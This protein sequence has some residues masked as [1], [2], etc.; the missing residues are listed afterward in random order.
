MNIFCLYIL[1]CYLFK[2][3]AYTNPCVTR[4]TTSGRRGCR[5]YLLCHKRSTRQRSRS[6]TRSSGCS[7]CDRREHVTLLH[8]A[9]VEDDV[10]RAQ[11]TCGKQNKTS[12]P[13]QKKAKGKARISRRASFTPVFSVS[14]FPFSLPLSLPPP[15]FLSPSVPPP[16]FPA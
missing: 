16:F 14:S 6:N 2:N 1:T 3:M 11:I 8:L 5:Q 9:Q 7:R 4:N 10:G 12:D 13:P 15:F